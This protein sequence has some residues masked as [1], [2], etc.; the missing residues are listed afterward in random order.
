MAQKDYYD[1]LGVSKNA[2]QDEIKKA[3]RKL[4]RKY[5][6]DHS[7]GDKGNEERFKE[8]SEAYAVLSDAE[9]RKQY[10]TYGSEDF[11]QRYSQEDIFRGSNL[12]DILREFGFG[13][14]SF[15]ANFG[16]GKKSAGMGGSRFS[17]DPESIFGFG[18]G[19]G[20][21]QQTARMKGGDVES[22]LPVTIY[23]IVHGATK[24]ISL[25]SPSG[26]TEQLTVKIPKGWITG[27]KLRFS[28]RGQ[29]SPYGGPAG[30]L[31]IRSK[32]VDDPMYRQEGHDL[33]IDREIKLTD[34]LLGTKISVP[35]VDGKQLSL[36]IPQGSQHKRKLRLAGR[37]IPH[38]KG[39]GVGDLYVVVNIKMPKS[40]SKKQKELVKQ[41]A[42]LGL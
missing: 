27:K 19:G 12:D 13:G 36:T 30:D 28:G 35:T 15:F 3:Y 37:G 22:E 8:I 25:Q 18:G 32:V 14:G 4:A 41:L 1:I 29:P 23:D 34:A 31:Y 33:Y 5:H 20:R 40:L 21:Q 24:T 39:G 9:K 42:E 16:R 10:D 6:P 2:S 11:Q 38:M 17:F 7:G 26:N